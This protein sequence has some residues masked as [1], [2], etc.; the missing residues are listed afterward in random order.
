MNSYKRKPLKIMILIGS[1]LV[2][3]VIVSACGGGGGSSQSAGVGGTGVSTARGTVQGRVTG[4][5]SIY[6]NGDKFNTDTS[7]FFVDGNPDGTQDDLAIGMIVTLDVETSEGVYTGKAFDVI[8]DDEVQGPV[9]NKPAPVPGSGGT[10]K[11]FDVFGQTIT[12]DATET[13]FEDTSFATLDANDVVE[14]SGF[15]SSPTEI[16]ASYVEWKETLVSGSDVE[17]RGTISGYAP[18]AQQFMLDGFLISFDRGVFHASFPVF[19]SRAA[20]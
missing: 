16:L 20:T 9:K 11:T 2:S 5:G 8:Y 18:L 15:R 4:F 10:Q 12:I 13:I 14:I 1:L 7:K 19:L 6:V 17:L 3:A